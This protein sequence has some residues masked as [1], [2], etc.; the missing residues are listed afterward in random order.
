RTSWRSRPNPLRRRPPSRQRDPEC[1]ARHPAW[2]GTSLS[3]DESGRGSQSDSRVYRIENR[4]WFYTESCRQL[5]SSTTIA[6]A[7]PRQCLRGDPLA[8]DGESRSREVDGLAPFFPIE[9]P[10]KPAAMPLTKVRR[11]T[12]FPVYPATQSGRPPIKSGV[13]SQFRLDSR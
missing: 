8:G 10:Q 5:A 11:V 7:S 2:G 4:C 6:T 12:V 9:H 3:S 13:Q 1:E